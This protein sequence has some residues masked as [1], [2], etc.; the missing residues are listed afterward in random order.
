MANVGVG[1]LNNGRSEFYQTIA[2]EAKDRGVSVSVI[3]MEGEDCSME[4]LGT[5]CV[6]LAFPLF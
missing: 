5:L 2:I 1:N 6:F 3:T 4:N